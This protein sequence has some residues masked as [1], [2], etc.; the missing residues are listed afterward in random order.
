M[1]TINNGGAHAIKGFNYQ[2]SI[3]VLIAVLHYLND[4]NFQIYVESEDDIVVTMDGKKTY[5]QSKSS[6]L[7]IP[8]IVKRKNDKDSIIEKNLADKDVESS[9]FKLICPS[10][11]GSDKYLSEHSASILT[12]GADIYFYNE[13]A[14]NKLQEKLPNLSKKK[15]NNSKVA[16]TSFRANQKDALTYITGVMANQKIPVD[17]SSGMASLKELCLEIDQRSEKIVSNT[18]DYEKKK[19]TQKDLRTIFSHSHEVKFYEEIVSSLNYSIA[20][21]VELKKKNITI[22]AIYSSYIDRAKRIIEELDIININ[23]RAVI[24][25]VLETM[26]LIIGIDELDREAIIIKAFSRVLFERSQV[27]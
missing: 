22:G 7:S 26:P 11:S 2:K 10:F 23:Q 13:L 24:D 4:N 21:Q 18:D 15:L 27:C 25:K 6:E 17:N 19:F 5:I 8:I 3:V 16:L 9:N 12:E 20:K 14:I 1:R